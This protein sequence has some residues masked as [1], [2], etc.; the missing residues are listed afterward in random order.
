MGEENPIEKWLL[1]SF[2]LLWLPCR[3]VPLEVTEAVR[4]GTE[5]GVTT[6]MLLGA[7]LGYAVRVQRG[8]GGVCVGIVLGLVYWLAWHALCLDWL[9]MGF[10]G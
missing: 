9:V 2:F 7:W 6:L 10:R 3:M 4:V 5:L 8:L 1:V